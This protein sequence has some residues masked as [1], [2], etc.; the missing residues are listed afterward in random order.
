[1][2]KTRLQSQ[3]FLTNVVTL[4][5]IALGAMG[6][7]TNLDPDATAV[8]ILSKDVEF[9]VTILVPG[10]ITIIFKVS[11]NIQAG[12]FDWKKLF[13]S[14]N[15]IT[16][17]ITVLAAML[18]TIGIMLP[19]TAPIELTNAIFGG[20]IAALVSAIVLNVINP[21][22]HWLQDRLKK[23]QPAPAPTPK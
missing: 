11:Q 6:V 16:Q 20:S 9:L 7:E 5:F 22:W 17:G 14:P 10:L 8:G 21:V 12:T 23:D 13:K 4:L 2:K 1:M 3:N 15:F 19:E 18:G